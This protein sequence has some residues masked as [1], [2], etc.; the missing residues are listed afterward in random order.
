LRRR[1]TWFLEETRFL[2]GCEVDMTLSHAVRLIAAVC[3][4]LWIAAP[5]LIAQSGSGL[6]ERGW[7]AQIDSPLPT[8]GDSPI[9][10]PIPD[11]ANC[12]SPFQPCNGL[13]ATPV[14]TFS[15]FLPGVTQPEDAADQPPGPPPDLGTILNYVAAGVV[16]VGGA[17]KIYWFFADR[18]KRST[19]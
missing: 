13:E 10:T 8:P 6:P 7:P 9:P 12:G 15:T 18:R 3:A 14:P 19:G 4:A 17:L 1:E 16:V 5:A 2:K 11:P